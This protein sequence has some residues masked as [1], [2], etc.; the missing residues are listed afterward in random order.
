M[1][2]HEGVEDL[3]EIWAHRG[4]SAYAPENTM[5]AFEK[6]VEMGAHGVEFDVQRTRDGHLVVIHD[7]NIGRVSN[8]VGRV[9]DMTL[10]ELRRCDFA[11]GF[12]G[13][14]RVP[15][16]T[17]EE[18][19]DFLAPTDLQ[20]N[21]ELKNSKEPYPGM[22]LEVA[23]V[24]RRDDMLERAVVSSFNHY[25]LANLRSGLGSARLGL[26]F[27][28]G[29]YDPWTYATWFGAGAIHPHYTA[30]QP[31]QTWLAHEA[32]VK[33]RMWTVNEPDDVARLAASG[34]DVV[35]TNFPDR[36]L[37]AVGDYARLAT[38]SA[39]S[40]LARGLGSLSR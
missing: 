39:E 6:A 20:L 24:L 40:S 33:V 30:L 14:R 29:L 16:P 12:V 38:S 11:N 28:D 17:L 5:P 7:E 18:V 22:E 35:I 25:S 13:Y 15:I 36:A 1:L 2:L 21:V 31:Q 34:V 23:E 4:A 32:G 9:V 27:A 8:G 19:L 10:E 3:T 37:R 26:L